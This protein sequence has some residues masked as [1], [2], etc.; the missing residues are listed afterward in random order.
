MIPPRLDFAHLKRTVDIEQVLADKEWLGRMRRRGDQIVGP[1][2]VHRGDNPNAFVVDRDKKLWH[3]FT[4]CSG[5]G[6]VVELARRL[7]GGSYRMAA[8]Y[9]ASLAGSPNP[10]LGTIPASG[11]KVPPV[12]PFRPFTKRLF[13]DPRIPWLEKKGIRPQ[14]ARRFQ[15]GAFYGHGFLAGCVAVRLIDPEGRPLG[16]AGRR[17]D[18]EQARAWGKWKLPRGLPRNTLLYGYHQATRLRRC[19]G[20]LVE[21]PWGVLRLAQLGIPAV[22]LL[23]THLSPVQRNLLHDLPKVVVMMDG[24]KAGKKAARTVNKQLANTAVVHLPDGLDPDDLD[25][26]ELT[27]S[28]QDHFFL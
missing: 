5:G 2:L 10:P 6:D 24:D 9:L 14:I 27:R 3:C 25:D 15:V 1:C 22:A 11:Q 26:Q 20:V 17:L 8:S 28:L 23:G 19:G 7:S 18:D 4:G 13:L 16:Y 12:R 21:C